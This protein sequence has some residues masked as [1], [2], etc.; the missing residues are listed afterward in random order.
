MQI[1][2]NDKIKTAHLDITG[3]LLAGGKSRRMGYDK[4]HLEFEGSSFF[5]NLVICYVSI[6]QP[7]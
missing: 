5:Q 7:S 1:M 6:S 2:R 3:V 4:A